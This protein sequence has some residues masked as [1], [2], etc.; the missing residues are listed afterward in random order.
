MWCG[1]D[2]DPM[3]THTGAYCAASRLRDDQVCRLNGHV[4]VD[5]VLLDRDAA[6][7]RDSATLP[8][9]ATQTLVGVGRRNLLR[10][11]NLVAG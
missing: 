1:I 3:I 8:A 7:L 2:F 6:G 4:T 11:M 10:S 5:A 9:V